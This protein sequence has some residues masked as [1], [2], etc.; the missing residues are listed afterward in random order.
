MEEYTVWQDVTV[1]LP[2]SVW[3]TNV[4]PKMITWDQ[5]IHY[6]YPFGSLTLLY[7]STCANEEQEGEGHILHSHSCRRRRRKTSSGFLSLYTVQLRHKQCSELR[8]PWSSRG[9]LVFVQQKM[10]H[11]LKHWRAADL[12]VIINLER[13]IWVVYFGNFI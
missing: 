10:H 9:Y 12:S 4:V 1:F 6:P 7:K 13:S 3:G 5:C 8:Y 11:F 2:V